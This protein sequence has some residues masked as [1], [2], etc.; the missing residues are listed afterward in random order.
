LRLG[1]RR[2]TTVSTIGVK[3]TNRPVM[4]AAFEVVVRSS[5]R[6]LQPVTPEPHHAEAERGD[7]EVMQARVDTR[8]APSPPKRDRRE[9]D[10]S[11][12]EPQQDE[13]GGR[14]VFERVLH[15]LERAAVRDRGRDEGELG[16][17]RPPRLPTV[18]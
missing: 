2:V 15:D 10:R 11:D 14:E 12:D 4:K 1:A 13:S 8:S 5:P 3:T 7:Q 6:V 9:R 17:Q 16:Q 18:G